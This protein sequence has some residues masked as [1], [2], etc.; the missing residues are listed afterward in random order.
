MTPSPEQHKGALDAA[1]HHDNHYVAMIAA[2]A[3]TRDHT[4]TTHTAQEHD[5]I[6]CQVIAAYLSALP[7]QT[8][9]R[10]RS[11][12]TAPKDGTH[13]LACDA[14]TRYDAWWTF[15]QRPP[16]VVHWWSNPGEEGFYTS[17][18]EVEPQV[19]FSPT[20]WRP[21]PAPPAGESP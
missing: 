14:S 12:E 10:W 9:E 11:I 19:P 6:V 20:H 2:A 1:D 4:R 5:D 3:A 17:V 15:M 8:G 7:E 16:T 21:L 13:I 18:N